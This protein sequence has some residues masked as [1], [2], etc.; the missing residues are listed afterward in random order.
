MRVRSWSRRR[1]FTLVE[2]MIVVALIGILSALAVVG[3]RKYIAAA[4]TSE[5]SAICQSIRAA[6]ESFRGET[7]LY[8]NVS[9]SGSYY[10]ITSGF[11]S[12]YHAWQAA[13]HPDLANWQALSIVADNVRF[14]YKVNAGTAGQ[15]VTV[16]TQTKV[17]PTW[18]NPPIEPWYVVQ[19]IGDPDGD[20]LNT[21]FVGSS[22]TGELYTEDF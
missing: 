18:P 19:A 21:L 10:P 4:K 16:A 7:M 15:A 9:V 6:E 1:G 12:K 11:D 13:S 14:G 3:Y 5:G 17:T 8:L 2:L 22:F 20:G